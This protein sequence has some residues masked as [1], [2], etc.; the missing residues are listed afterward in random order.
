[1]EIQHNGCFI[2]AFAVT[3]QSKLKWYSNEHD[4]K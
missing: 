4:D 2:E 3:L 1:M